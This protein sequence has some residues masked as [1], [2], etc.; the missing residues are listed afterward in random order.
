MSLD[1]TQTRD[2]AD[3]RAARLARRAALEARVLHL[4]RDEEY[5]LASIARAVGVGT[6][7]AKSILRRHG[8]VLARREA[9]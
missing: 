5:G 1:K 7:A 3:A 9:L 2:L 8:V 6:K 4:A